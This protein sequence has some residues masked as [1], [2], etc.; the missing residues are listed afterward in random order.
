MEDKKIENGFNR[1]EFIKCGAFLG[2]SLLASQLTWTQELMRRAEAGQLTPEEEYEL[3]KPE[4]I[5]YSVCLQCN[6][7]CGIKVKLFRKNG[8]ALALKIDG[9]PYSPFVSLP[10]TPYP[11]SPF[12]VNNVDMAI[13][14]KGQAGIQTVYDPYRITKVLKRAG[15]RG[16]NKWMTIP[17]DQAI[18]EIVNGGL[19]FKHVPGE[20]NRMVTGLKEIYALR[21]PKVAK[22]MADDVAKI[23]KEKDKKKAI[24]E[25]KKKHTSNL[26]Y[27]IDPDHPDLGPKIINWSICGV[28]RR[29][30]EE[31]LL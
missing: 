14:P 26:H 11:T 5:L 25:F 24:E 18:N 2:G 29:V 19:L 8:Q 3:I 23:L 9:N 6:T 10:H 30:E 1:R 21:D 13:C 28:E 31:N 16:E 22:E 27:L 12:E 7:G 17:F 4:N 15:K 20:E